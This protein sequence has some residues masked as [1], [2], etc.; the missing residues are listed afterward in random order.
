MSK[1]ITFLKYLIPFTLLLYFAQQYAS[2]A[3]GSQHHFFFTTWSIYLFQFIASLLLYIV[4]L[5]VH[6][7]FPEYKE[8]KDSFLKT[9]IVH[10][11]LA[12]DTNFCKSIYNN[13]LIYNNKIQTYFKKND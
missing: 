2:T 8:F 12:I 3:L 4:L 9:K 10:D 11:K 7:K 5:F 13:I 6:S 1:L